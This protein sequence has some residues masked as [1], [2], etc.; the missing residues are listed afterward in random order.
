[1]TLPP[2]RCAGSLRCWLARSALLQNRAVPSLS[3]YRLLLMPYLSSFLRRIST[4]YGVLIALGLLIPQAYAV[5]TT[6]PHSVPNTIAQRVAACFVCHGQEGRASSAGYLPR[7]AGKPAGYLYNQLLNFRED[8]RHNAAMISFVGNLS[9]AYLWEIASYFAALDLPY[10]APSPVALTVEQRARGETLALRGDASRQLPAC[11]QCHGPQLMGMQP[12][13][14]G[15]LGLPRD[16][17]LSQ[18]GSWRTQSRRAMAPDCMAD[19]A[20]RLSPED[21]GAVTAWLSQQPVPAG[22]KPA[23]PPQAVAD[24]AGASKVLHC[25]SVAK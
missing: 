7:I 10:P 15:L 2:Y 11:N 19:I 14:P 18:L 20:G 9:D 3:P 13:T 21:L 6:T 1:M 5:P 8:R 16:Y 4:L 23:A 12:A 17:L 24:A 22:A 25:G